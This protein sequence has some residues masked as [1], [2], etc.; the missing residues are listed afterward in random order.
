MFEDISLSLAS[1]T[2]M[3]DALLN[4][5]TNYETTSHQLMKIF[6][7]LIEKG[8]IQSTH[9]AARSIVKLAMKVSKLKHCGGRREALLIMDW[10]EDNLENSEC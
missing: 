4:C 2:E 10:G 7:R 1:S 3:L 5:P 8:E 9:S 6:L